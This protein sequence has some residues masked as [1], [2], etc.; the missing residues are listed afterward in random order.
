MENLHA[1]LEALLFIYGEPLEIKKIVK[2]LSRNSENI[3]ESQV[4]T[5]LH[6]LKSKLEAADRGLTLVVNDDYVELVT[7]SKFTGLLEQ[8]TKE[9]LKESLTP[10]A[11]EALSIIAY[12]GPVPRSVIDYIRGVNSTFILRMLLLRGLIDRSFDP[13][14]ANTYIYK[15]SFELLRYLGLSR[16]QDLPEYS[17]FRELIEKLKPES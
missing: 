14:R 4:K 6:D 1:K 9:E 5:A 2:I 12:T 3:N 7:K 11:L 16:A 8:V 15:P 10:A 17:R 13:K